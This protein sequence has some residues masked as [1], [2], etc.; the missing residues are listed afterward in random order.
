MQ[1]RKY[2]SKRHI[3][4]KNI[5]RGISFLL[6]LCMV[7][8]LF[9]SVAVFAQE[10]A[11]T[12]PQEP[13]QV[14]RLTET[15]AQT[16]ARLL[17]QIREDNWDPYSS[18]MTMDEFY[19]LMELFQEGTLPLEDE[20]PAH[21]APIIGAP[22]MEEPGIEDG[23]G[24]EG[25]SAQPSSVYIPR[26]MF[27]FSGLNT[28]SK[29][30][31]HSFGPPLSYDNINGS[32]GDYPAGLDP[33]GGYTR[34]PESW[35]GIDISSSMSATVVVP[36]INN[37]N[38]AVSGDVDQSLFLAYENV[39]VRQVTVQNN[40]V[41]VLGAIQHK[42]ELVYYYTTDEDQLIQVSATTLGEGQKF[43]IHYA[44]REYSI[45]YQ[46][47]YRVDV[48]KDDFDEQTGTATLFGFALERSFNEYGK[49]YDNYQKYEEA[50]GAGADIADWVRQLPR[51]ADETQR[52]DLAALIFGDEFPTKTDEGKYAF[53]A[54]APAGYT[55]AFY[56][57]DT[58][59]NGG[60]WIN[61]S[62]QLVTDEGF[63]GGPGEYKDVNQGWALGMEPVY[64]YYTAEEGD[65]KMMPVESK[66][67]QE[68][69]T[70]GTFYNND[71]DADRIVVAVLRKKDTPTFDAYNLINGTKEDGITGSTNDYVNGRGTSA[72]HTVKAINRDT[73]LEETILY[74]YEDAFLWFKYGENAEGENR[75]KY[76]YTTSGLGTTASPGNL[77]DGNVA[78]IDAA[79]NW[80]KSGKN[81]AVFHEM[82]PVTDENGVTTY[83]Y[84]WTWQTNDSENYVLDTLE[85]NRIGITVPFHAKRSV[86]SNNYDENLGNDNGDLLSWWAETTLPDGAVVKVELLI[87]FANRPQRV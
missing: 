4:T 28:D 79:W 64:A 48:E 1:N 41:T 12:V 59:D 45:S 85:I 50:V 19:A 65:H 15:K 70:T 31:G 80:N 86:R 7:S 52:A 62:A 51:L 10:P 76:K 78:T 38:T 33:Y 18:D 84:Q 72:V 55:L 46:I 49:Y 81:D 36:G 61:G 6:S 29:P 58:K 83:S 13:A 25:L 26:G 8:S 71:V 43:V 63:N 20:D 66:G 77:S 69:L 37:G 11:Q 27:L 24:V 22:G 87:L 34:P 67:P 5:R 56:L 82:T 21:G 39:Y 23:P 57:S 9:C 42:N 68:L 53:T 2:L 44:H 30:D 74:D 47:R 73:G 75:S 3:F 60:T 17:R 14:N 35:P 40:P 54:T 16:K 32:D